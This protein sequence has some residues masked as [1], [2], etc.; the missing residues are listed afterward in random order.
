MK[1]DCCHPSTKLDRCPILP[2]YSRS[3]RE[4]SDV[5]NVVAALATVVSI[6]NEIYYYRSLIRGPVRPM[7]GY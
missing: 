1:Y 2:V 4:M 5:N 7:V 6:R 3:K